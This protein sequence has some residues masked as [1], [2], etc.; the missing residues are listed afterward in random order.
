MSYIVFGLSTA[1]SVYCLYLCHNKNDRDSLK[2]YGMFA[3]I[4]IAVSMISGGLV[5]IDLGVIQ[6]VNVFTLLI[7][8]LIFAGVAKLLLKPGWGKCKETEKCD[9]W[10]STM[11]RTIIGGILTL[12]GTIGIGAMVIAAGMELVGEWVTIP[13]RVIC[14]ILSN[15]TVVPT[16]FF[17]AMLIVGLSI[18]FSEYSKKGE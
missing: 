3:Y 1:F 18:L 16:V 7:I 6:Q 8:Y 17:L 10:R 11:K 14:T 12:C 9:D 2:I 4:G 5:L 13:G 15:G